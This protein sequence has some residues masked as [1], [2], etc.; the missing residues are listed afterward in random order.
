MKNALEKVKIY[1]GVMRVPNF[2]AIKRNCSFLTKP[3]KE[4]ETTQRSE[5]EKWYWI[6]C[7]FG[8]NSNNI[9]YYYFSLA[10]TS[11]SQSTEVALSLNFFSMM[12]V[13]FP[14]W[15]RWLYGIQLIHLN[16]TQIDGKTRKQGPLHSMQWSSLILNVSLKYSLTL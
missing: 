9:F 15:R 12:Q 8:L 5:F 16:Q 11:N 10:H 14:P 2:T 6:I 3:R 4:A 1:S 13:T 7:L